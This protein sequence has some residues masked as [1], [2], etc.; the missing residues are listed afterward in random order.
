MKDGAPLLAIG[1]P[2]GSQIIGY[3]AQ[4][5]IAYIDWGMPVEQIVAQPHLINRFGK[6]DLEAGT[7]AEKFA[8]PLNALGFDVN[9]TEM[10]SGL[11]AIEITADRSCGKCRSAPRRCGDRRIGGE[12][13][14]S[15]RAGSSN[16]SGMTQM[17]DFLRIDPLPARSRLTRATLLLLRRPEPRLRRAACAVSDLLLAGAEAV[18][19]LRL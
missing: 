12:T 15:C 5:L 11:H 16:P 10:N 19:L 17:L 9:L 8:D 7:A 14:F 3:V 18:V 1:S 6:Y 2:G 13:V 4:A